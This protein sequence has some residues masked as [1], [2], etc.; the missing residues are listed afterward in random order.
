MHLHSPPFLLAF[1]LFGMMLMEILNLSPIQAE[2]PHITT[3]D[4]IIVTGTANPTRLSRSTQSLT[5]I[6][7]EQYA[8]LLP[9]RIPALSTTGNA[10]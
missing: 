2:E 10:M 1:A 9:N 6:E 5:V 7:R 8:P 4:P 3:L